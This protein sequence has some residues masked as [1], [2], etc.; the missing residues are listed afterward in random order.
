MTYDDT[1][2]LSEDDVELDSESEVEIEPVEK[3]DAQVRRRIDDLLERKR[4]RELLDDTD[5]W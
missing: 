1:D 2:D 5:D 3:K 4:L